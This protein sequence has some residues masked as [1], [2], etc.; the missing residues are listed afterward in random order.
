MAFILGLVGVLVLAVCTAKS[1]KRIGIVGF[2]FAL[3]YFPIG[4]ILSLAKKYK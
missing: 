1:K 3:L 2:F 4:I